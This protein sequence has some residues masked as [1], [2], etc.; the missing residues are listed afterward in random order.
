MDMDT[1][2]YRTNNFENM[3]IDIVYAE[4][5]GNAY[6]DIMTLKKSNMM[7]EKNVLINL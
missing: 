7:S 4:D 3:A 5:T 2:T 6:E 1:D